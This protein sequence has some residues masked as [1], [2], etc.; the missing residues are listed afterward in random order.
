MIERMFQ[1][2]YVSGF[3]FFLF[4]SLTHVPSVIKEEVGF[5]TF[6]AAKTHMLATIV[7]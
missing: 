1:E 2:N 4:S 3:F 7:M 6:A 5:K